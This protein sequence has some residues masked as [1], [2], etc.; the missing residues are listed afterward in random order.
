MIAVEYSRNRSSDFSS[1]LTSDSDHLILMKNEWSLSRG[2]TIFMSQIF[3]SI[4]IV[5]DEKNYLQFRS[6][7]TSRFDLN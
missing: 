5:Y 4:N 1:D 3:S 6:L 2:H 7:L